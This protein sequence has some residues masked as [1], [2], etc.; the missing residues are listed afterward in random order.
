M[1][2]AKSVILERTRRSLTTMRHVVPD[3]NMSTMSRTLFLLFFTLATPATLGA[4]TSP[5]LVVTA[6]ALLKRS[7]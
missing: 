6:A 4:R 7:A 2:S 1:S 5:N 3:R